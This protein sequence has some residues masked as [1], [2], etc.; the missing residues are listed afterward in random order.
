MTNYLSIEGYEGIYEVSAC[1]LVRSLDRLVDKGGV[2]VKRRGRV[3]KAMV[4]K[5]GYAN[6]Y[7][8][9]A[10]DEKRCRVHRLVAAAHLPGFNPNL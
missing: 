9:V 8:S 2:L 10:G 1:G 4:D 7:L 3:L 6:V 5:Y